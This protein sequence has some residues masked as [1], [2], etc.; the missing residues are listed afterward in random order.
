MKNPYTCGSL[1][2]G[3]IQGAYV[4]KMYSFNKKYSA[5]NCAKK[6]CYS[7]R[8]QSGWKSVWAKFVVNLESFVL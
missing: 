2:F 4:S 1:T 8:R 7:K 6:L 3:I 5:Y